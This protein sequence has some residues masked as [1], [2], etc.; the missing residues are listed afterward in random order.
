MNFLSR[1]AWCIAIGF[2]FGF[3]SHNV[4]NFSADLLPL[5]GLMVLVGVVV[6]LFE[7]SNL[8]PVPQGTVRQVQAISTQSVSE[9]GL[10]W[11]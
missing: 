7:F 9:K 5:A 6:I 4:P 10:D 8:E 3:L 11:R 1:F 2:A